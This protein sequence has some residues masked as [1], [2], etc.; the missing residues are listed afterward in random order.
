MPD[1]YTLRRLAAQRQHTEAVMA[2]ARDVVHQ[3]ALEQRKLRA[4]RLK[5]Q[6]ERNAQA[7]AERE[8][9]RQEANAQALLHPS[10]RRRIQNV[11]RADA[12]AKA[13]EGAPENKMLGGAPENKV[14]APSAGPEPL[15][16]VA[17]ASPMARSTALSWGMTAKDFAGRTP[18]KVTGFSAADVRA[19][20][21]AAH[22]VDAEA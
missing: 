10:Q 14:E 22:P 20:Y 13:L 1:R 5:E 16:G 9:L 4:Q 18:S 12:A 19:A 3:D 11:A 8:R 21:E 15:V 2:G 17:F 7:T 6:A